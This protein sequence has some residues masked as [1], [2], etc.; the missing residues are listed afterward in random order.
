MTTRHVIR[1]ELIPILG[2]M[3]QPTGFPDLG[4]ATFTR[5]DSGERVASLLVESVQSMANRLEAT[6]WGEATN[7]PVAAVAGLPYV[8][9]VRA[10]SGEFLTSSRL[11]AHRLASPYVHMSTL[12]GKPMFEEITRRLALVKDTPHDRRAMSLGV[13]GLDPFCLVH[14]AFFSHK[15]WWGQPKFMR[16][17]SGVI[18]AYEVERAISGGRKSDRV[19]LGLDG[20]K[21]ATS[22]GFGSVPFH[23]TEWTAKTIRASFV[24]D[25][26]LLRSYGLPEPVTEVLETL[27]LWEIRSLIDGGLRLR[28]AC[29]LQL[30]GDVSGD[31][32]VLGELTGR[33]GELIP[34]CVEALGS[35]GPL[36]VEYAAK[37]KA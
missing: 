10:G 18:E 17:V 4:A 11:E 35:G 6:A 25:V 19:R 31:L 8:R 37:K 27:A 12:D 32:P 15:D 2:T 1:A 36:V 3:F 21:G 14:G 5:F 24:V 7:E 28:T 26:E 34:G 16:A 33:L 22:E 9:V 13:A 23:R 29:D 20:D 30:A